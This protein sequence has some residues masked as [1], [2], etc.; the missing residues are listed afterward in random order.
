MSRSNRRREAAEAADAE[1]D[2][3]VHQANRDA[4][5]RLSTVLNTAFDALDKTTDPRARWR[6]EEIIFG[7][8]VLQDFRTEIKPEVAAD[9]LARIKD[10]WS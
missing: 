5:P 10:A 9:Y 3:R 8:S 1:L 4:T 2:A 6:L 7:L